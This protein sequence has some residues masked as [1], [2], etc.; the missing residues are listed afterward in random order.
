M[1]DRL[2]YW[3]TALSRDLR[4]FADRGTEPKFEN[5]DN[6]L[7]VKWQVRG[8][9]REALFSLKP[10]NRLRWTPDSGSSADEPY[11]SFL[12]SD[13]M[14]GFQ[15]LASACLATIPTQPDFLA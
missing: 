4:G 14:A 2:D 11:F 8:Q 15:P 6:M 1:T 7:G 12:A 5:A 10:G 9:Q 13:A 3:K